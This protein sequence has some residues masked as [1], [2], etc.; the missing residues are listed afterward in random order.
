VVRN[1]AARVGNGP[2]VL[3]SFRRGAATRSVLMAPSPVEWV[4]AP[5]VPVLVPIGRPRPH[6]GRLV[7]LVG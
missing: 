2:A 5:V 7:L 6:S 1:Q 4:N 3:R